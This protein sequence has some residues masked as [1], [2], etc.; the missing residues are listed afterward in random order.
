MIDVAN[1][2]A[3]LAYTMEHVVKACRALKDPHTARVLG[4]VMFVSI[5]SFVKLA[6]VHKNALRRAGTLQSARLRGA[7]AKIAQLRQDYEAWYA[8]LRDKL[9]AHQQLLPLPRLFE[10]WND[11]D[12]AS[13]SIFADDAAAVQG[14]L[15]G[16]SLVRPIELD[17]HGVYAA[18]TSVSG[19]SSEPQLAVDRVAHTRPNT[20]SII[21]AHPTQEK[22]QRVLTAIDNIGT[23]TTQLPS[24]QASF[25]VAWK[26][27]IDLLV[28]D[29]CSLID[30]LFVDR[31]ADR[32]GPEDPSLMTL[33]ARDKFRGAPHLQAFPRDVQ[34]EQVLRDTRNR[35]CAHLDHRLSLQ[36]LLWLTRALPMPRLSDY[37]GALHGRF[38]EACRMD[39][40]TKL[41][42]LQRQTLTGV[43]AV[44][45]TGLIR[46][47]SS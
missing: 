8:G 38:L 44:C 47:F 28:L 36:Q 23:L 19:V 26:A 22:A 46:P 9:G 39:I 42:L 4:R 14:L 30:N 3:F 13:L 16:S 40:R 37:V 29:I 32:N 17:S 34:L 43:V 2:L 18:Y 20:V 12:A 6:P 45:D 21:A 31:P 7:E 25:A 15:G 1:K 33:W 35:A 10:L 24:V 41:F 11:I 27:L 5:D